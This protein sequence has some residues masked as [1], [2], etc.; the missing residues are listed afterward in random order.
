MATARSEARHGGSAHERN[1]R[2]GPSAQLKVR[3]RAESRMSA[4]G[5]TRPLGT[6]DRMAG[7]A[8]LRPL[9]EQS[10]TAARVYSA[11][12]IP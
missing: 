3:C 7:V 5:R 4:R 2:S 11:T 10:A 9:A 6:G 1:E 8:A 12:S